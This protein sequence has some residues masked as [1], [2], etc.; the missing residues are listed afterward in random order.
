MKQENKQIRQ[1]ITENPDQMGKKI[2]PKIGQ[3]RKLDVSAYELH[4]PDMKLMLISDYGTDVDNWIQWG[5][6]PVPW[7]QDK[8]K[9]FKGINDK[10]HS[11]YVNFIGGKDR[12]GNVYRLWLLMI[13]PELYDEIKLAPERERQEQIRAAMKRGEN[14]SDIAK[15]LPGGGGINTYAPTLPDGKTTGFN[16]I[17]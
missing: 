13:D 16:R 3:N 5:A 2:R 4:Y 6:Q 8:Q 1:P 17:S 10:H 9:T 11:E 12:G 14:Q 15:H 7:L